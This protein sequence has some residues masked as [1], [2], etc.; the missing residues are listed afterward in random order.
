[1]GTA[2]QGAVVEQLFARFFLHG[3]NIGDV[4]VLA[5]AADEAGMDGAAVRG[6]PCHRSRCGCGAR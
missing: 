5:E 6:R 3:E 1:M 2:T 4:A